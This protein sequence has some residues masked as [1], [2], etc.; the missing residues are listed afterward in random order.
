MPNTRSDLEPAT[1]EN[2]ATH[3]KV[4]CMFNPNEYTLAKQNQWNADPTKGLNVPKVKFKQGGAESL[5]LQLFFDTYAEGTD[6]RLH[7]APL[8]KMMMVSDDKRNE[9]NNKSEPPRV[10]FHWGALYFQAV[11]TSISQ[12]FTLFSRAGFPLRTTVDVTFQQADD[13]EEHAGQNPTS[14]SG[15]PRKTYTV[16]AGDRLDLIAFKVYEDASHWRLIARENGLTNPLRLR[17]GQQLVIPPL[18]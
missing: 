12:K 5:K 18:E 1:I 11:I 13:P 4:C 16:Q 9:R 14:G 15:P 2:L 6:V 10:A 3:E 7:T 17:E 8:W